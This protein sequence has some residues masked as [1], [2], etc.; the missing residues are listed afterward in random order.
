MYVYFAEWLPFCKT[1]MNTRPLYFAMISPSKI[2]DVKPSKTRDTFK[3]N[4]SGV[5][6]GQMPSQYIQDVYNH[7]DDKYLYVKVEKYDG[8][9]MFS[10]VGGKG[11]DKV[12]G[13]FVLSENQNSF[14]G[15]VKTIPETN[16]S[17]ELRKIIE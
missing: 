16:F 1:N 13:P 2:T 15:R 3:G 10:I 14:F 7:A 5:W 9:Y 12:A 11:K 4:Y 6:R 8:E 17:L